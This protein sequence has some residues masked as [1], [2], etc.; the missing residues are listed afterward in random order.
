MHSLKVKIL[1]FLSLS[2]FGVNVLAQVENKNNQ[3]PTDTTAIE[4]KDVVINSTKDIKVTGLTA[5]KIVFNPES[6]STMPSLSGG[7]DLLKLLELTPGVQN[8]G[9]ANSN[10]YVRGGDPGQNLLIY[11]DIPLYSSGHLLG[12]FSLFNSDHIS[13][14]E[15]HK[16]GISSRYGG[17]LSSVINVTTPKS[18]P[19]KTSVKA[20]VGL[21]AT[22]F[23]VELPIS[24]KFGL[25]LSGRKTYLEWIIQPLINSTVNN[26]A[27]NKVEE[28]NYDFFDTNLTLIGK[29]SDKDRLTV[30]AM[31]GKDKF[32]INDMDM[33]L[34][35]VL[36]WQNRLLSL[37]WDR[38]IGKNLFTQQVYFS[39]YLN[40]LSSDQAQ[41]NMSIFSEIQDLSY[42]NRYLFSVNHIA[43]ETGIQYAYHTI[44]PQS[45]TITNISTINNNITD[46]IKAHEANIYGDMKFD[47]NPRFSAE[48]GIRA[49]LFHYNTNIFSVEPRAK[50]SYQLNNTSIVRLAYHRQNQFMNM[51]SPTSVGLPLEFWVA[52]GKELP[53]QT[54]DDISAGYNISLFDDA[55]NLSVDAYYRSMRNVNEYNQTITS[56]A[57]K[58]YLDNTLSGKGRAY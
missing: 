56:D 26:G 39:N 11:D 53:H 5:G 38:T 22:Q 9:D 10:T 17:R 1:L 47:I 31:W 7:T 40:N 45:I 12:F 21:L 52:A 48:L 57:N 55:I 54:G 43:F 58:T 46:K 44:Q 6:M 51:L 29:V 49:N 24:E 4:L 18:I 42:R 25:Y 2:L 13:S 35:G 41:V 28:L 33:S 8:A 16:S 32:F 19:N 27:K 23:T 37:K 30:N 34:D 15:L 36:N 50:L 14:L 20:N 3:T